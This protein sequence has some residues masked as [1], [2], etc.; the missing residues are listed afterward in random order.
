MAAI[1]NP[2]KASGS[3]LALLKAIIPKIN[4]ITGIIKLNTNPNFPPCS[5]GGNKD[6]FFAVRQ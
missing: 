3:S 4:P 6:E 1:A 5:H 2:F